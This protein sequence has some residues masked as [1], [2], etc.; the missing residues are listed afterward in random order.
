VGQLITDGLAAKFGVKMLY[1][2]KIQGFHGSVEGLEMPGSPNNK[3]LKVS[4]AKTN[5]APLKISPR[6][7]GSARGH[8]GVRSVIAALGTQDFYRIRIGV[9]YPKQG[10][11]EQFVMERLS[12]EEL[13][14]WRPGGEGIEKVWE[15]VVKIIED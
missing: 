15:A 10:P 2:P 14:Y 11:L 3:R 9:G 5:Q 6:F 7:G 13:E 4:F 1:E 8:N 12:D